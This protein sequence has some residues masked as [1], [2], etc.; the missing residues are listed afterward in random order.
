MR[1]CAT[2]LSIAASATARRDPGQDARVEWLGDDVVLVE[3]ETRIA[4]RRAYIV[5]HVL[6][7]QRRERFGG[8]E[9]H[10]VIDDRSGHIERAAKDVRE[11]QYVVDLVGKVAAPGGRDRIRPGRQG[12][13][14]GDLRIRIGQRE[15][16]RPV[17]H[18]FEHVGIHQSAA[19]QAD[20][21]I[22]A[23]DRV[24]QR[25]AWIARGPR[26][27]GAKL[28]EVAL[29]VLAYDAFAVEHDDVLAFH[30]EHDP[31]LHAGN[32]RRAGADAD[33]LQRLEPLVL[34][35]G[36]ILERG[37]R[38]DRSAVLVVV[39]HGNVHPLAQGT[40]DQKAVGRFDI[41]QVDP[42]E[43]RLERSDDV[44]ELVGIG[45]IDLDVE[46]VDVGK[47]L[48]QD[49]FA[50]HHGL[51]RTRSDVAQPEHRR[52]VRYDGDE[53][54]PGGVE[55]HLR[56]IFVDGAAWLG[57]ARRIR[58]RQVALRRHRFGGDDLDF[59]GSALNVVVERVLLP[60]HGWGMLTQQARRM[61]L[62][63]SAVVAM[64][65]M[66]LWLCCSASET[67]LAQVPPGRLFIAAGDRI[68][69]ITGGD[70]IE[71]ARGLSG[72]Q[73]LCLLDGQLYVSEMDS[74]E[75]TVAT[76]GGDLSPAPPF[77]SGIAEPYAL[78]C[79]DGAILVGARGDG[80]IIDATAG[81]DLSAALPF[82]SGLDST[83]DLM[84]D[85]SGTL[86]AVAESMAG[87]RIVDATAGGDLS[88]QSFASADGIAGITPFRDHLFAALASRAIVTFEDGGDL[89]VVAASLDLPSAPGAM[90][91]L[92]SG[93]LYI[94][95]ANGTVYDTTRENI[96]F[97]EGLTS[98][99]FGGM[100]YSH[101]CGDGII[102]PD[103]ACDDGNMPLSCNPD[104]TLSVC[105]D[106][107]LSFGAEECDD[108]NT[109]SGDGCSATCSAEFTIPPTPDEEGC[110]CSTP[111]FGADDG[112]AQWLWLAA[113]LSFMRGARGWRSRRR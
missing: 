31:Q 95:S 36:G 6:T 84:R 101:V 82:A 70:M 49:A 83:G 93:P 25:L 12:L 10:L 7:R 53:V 63:T 104:C 47:A 58:E 94:A 67:A 9:L 16:D 30:A 106:G 102:A 85:E 5:R 113:L 108:G 100:A 69:D 105:G 21:H 33:D 74:G 78:S 34:K 90:L 17:A 111:G 77:A 112:R 50:F 45:F 29:T 4:V 64:Q 62:C 72:A 28:L 61:R 37:C 87:S 75:I 23:V 79:D 48:E 110:T 26:E 81:G 35:L 8:G 2:P 89:N 41:L 38:D 96:V 80:S 1:S 19:R 76:D 54:A 42:A 73:D 68:I 98:L 52:S 60:N 15:D 91:G 71:H 92:P 27:R 14:V 11:T 22:R 103:E 107:L 13:V 39:E 24:I 44:D 32:G 109:V 86:W 20:Q 59:S 56:R 99:S 40:F 66:V 97:V 51:G 18:A 88:S 3:L 43:S 65:L 57:H 46:H 55:V